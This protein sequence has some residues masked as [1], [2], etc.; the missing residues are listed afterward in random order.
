MKRSGGV[1]EEKSFD[2][3]RQKHRDAIESRD[4]TRSCRFRIL[5]YFL[6]AWFLQSIRLQTATPV[7]CST[8]FGGHHYPVQMRF[9]RF[10]DAG[11]SRGPAVE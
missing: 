3:D 5:L 4:F 6:C 9:S 7:R 10:R 2:G 11:Y 1:G 8:A